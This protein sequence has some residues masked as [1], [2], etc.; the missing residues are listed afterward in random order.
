MKGKRV[1]REF[2]LHKDIAVMALLWLLLVSVAIVFALQ[3]SSLLYYGLGMVVFMFSEYFTHRFI[4]HLKS[5]KNRFLLKLMKRLHYDHHKYP[6][7]F[8]LLFLPL[9]YSIPSLV[10]LV[11]IFFSITNDMFSTIAY[12]A[13]V[14]M[15]LLTY[16]WKHY[17]AHRPIKPRTKFGRWVKRMHILHHFKNENYWYG[18]STPFVDVLFRTLKD[19]REVDTSTTVKDL[20]NR[21]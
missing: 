7:D 10:L 20:E 17:V 15:M 16:E 4:F 9:W 2:F 18:V 1:Y 12:A 3:W 6:N 13:G 11:L 14:V 21:Q 5:P 8:N 19:G